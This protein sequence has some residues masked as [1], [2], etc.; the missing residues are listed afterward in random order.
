MPE[1][2]FK[3]LPF[4]FL[5]CAI[6]YLSLA[7]MP[8]IPGPTLSDKVLHTLA[9]AGITFWGFY[10]FPKGGLKLVAFVIAWGILIE[11]LQWL[12]PTRMLELL[13]MLANSLGAFIGWGCFKIFENLCNR[14]KQ[15]FRA[16]SS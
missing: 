15:I 16:R 14:A 12:T 1:F 6:T 4:F 5:I 10:G 13:D 3:R 7:P 2:T 8:E 9:Y 11:L